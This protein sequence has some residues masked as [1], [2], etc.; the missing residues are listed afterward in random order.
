MCE[1]VGVIKEGVLIKELSINELQQYTRKLVT[2]AG[3]DSKAALAGYKRLE[4]NGE[5][6]VFSV[7]REAIKTFLNKLNTFDY[8]DIQIRNPSLEESFMAFYDKGGEE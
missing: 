6:T 2:V 3:L 1:K 8:K 7:K 4:D 5:K